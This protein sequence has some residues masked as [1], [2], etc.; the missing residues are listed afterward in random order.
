MS[1]GATL[2]ALLKNRAVSQQLRDLAANR[3]V[4]DKSVNN[5]AT[6]FESPDREIDRRQYAKRSGRN[7]G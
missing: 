7:C 2:A 5:T 1:F 4:R 3:K 6:G